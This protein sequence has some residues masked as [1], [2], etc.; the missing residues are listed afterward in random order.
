MN[1]AKLVI[2]VIVIAIFLTVIIVIE[3]SPIAFFGMDFVKE[4]VSQQIRNQNSKEIVVDLIHD[5]QDYSQECF[6][7]K[8]LPTKA[9]IQKII[10]GEELI[11]DIENDFVNEYGKEP[12]DSEFKRHALVMCEREL[13]E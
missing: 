1:L 6:W 4:Q 12:T 2:V 9:K 3:S 11:A 10:G 7:A 8:F 5:E 13:E